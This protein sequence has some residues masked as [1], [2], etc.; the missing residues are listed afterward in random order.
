MKMK[1]KSKSPQRVTLNVSL[2]KKMELE[3][4]AIELSYKVGESINWTDIA[5]YM[6]NNY[7]KQAKEDIQEKNSEEKKD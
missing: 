7:I 4:A 1:S 5:H 2:Q 3:K 6:L